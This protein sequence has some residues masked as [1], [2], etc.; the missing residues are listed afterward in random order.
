MLVDDVGPTADDDRRRRSRPVGSARARELA[1]RGDRR[2]ARRSDRA[3]RVRRRG[4]ALPADRGPRRRGASS[5]TISARPICRRA[6]TSARCSAC[7]AAC[8]A[9]TSTRTSGCA[10][11]GAAR[12]RRRSAARREASTR[13]G[14]HDDDDT[15]VQQIERGKAIVIFTDGGDPDAEALR[16]VATR[17]RA[18]HRGVLRRRRHRRRAASCTTSTV[19]RPAHAGQAPATRRLDGDVEARRRRD[20][21]ARRGR[22]ATKRY[23]L[24]GETARST[25]CRS[26]T[27]FAAVNRGLAT[28]QRQGACATSTSRSCSRRSCCS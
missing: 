22:A 17:A 24:A 4:V 20:E 12:P 15:V 8:C 13:P 2:A 6:R 1:G 28:K 16:E 18:R 19:H 10:K 14:K 26:S 5:S 21:D 11:L 23:L 3:G 27:R 25:R 9:P 7:R